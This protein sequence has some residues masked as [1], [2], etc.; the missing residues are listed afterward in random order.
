MCADV[1]DVAMSEH[2]G[3]IWTPEEDAQLR[4]LAAS[5]VRP[6]EVAKRLRRTKGAIMT[7]AYEV[8]VT[9]G[10]AES[11]PPIEKEKAY[12][13]DHYLFTSRRGA[14][15]APWFW[16]IRRKS[17]PEQRSVSNGG[18]KSAKAAE[19]AGRIVLMQIRDEISEERRQNPINKKQ[20][21]LSKIAKKSLEAAIAK[22]R[23][24]PLTPEQRSELARLAAHARAQV[25][26]AERRKEIGR[27]GGAASKEKAMK[28]RSARNE[29]R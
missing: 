13:F 14:P 23:K 16:E 20:E 8:R 1:R 17:R 19:E 22:V 27:M 5:G 21:R 29:S 15:P 28:R 7:R 25:L 26:T 2:S 6:A 9:F 12:V 11:K 24:K 4:D 3:K 18:F 10:R